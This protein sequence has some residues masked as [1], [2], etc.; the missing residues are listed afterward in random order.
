MVNAKFEEKGLICRIDHRAYER[1]GVDIVPTVHEGVAVRQ[2]EAKG[3]TTDKGDLNRWIKKSNSLLRDI[4]RKIADLT[5]WIL[6]MKEELSSP[7]PPNLVELL[8]DFY[9]A[10]NASA[11]SNKAK[12]GNLKY[13]SKAINFLTEN[14]LFSLEDLETRIAQ[15]SDKLAAAKASMKAKS[16]RWCRQ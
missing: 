4:R 14:Q 9:A 6:E 12:V 16:S 11:W 8:S 7:P 1:Q 2:M 5:N 15:H 13:F 3:M 10:R